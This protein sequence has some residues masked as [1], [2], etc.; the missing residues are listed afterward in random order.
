MPRPLHQKTDRRIAVMSIPHIL[1]RLPKGADLLEALHDLCA[2]HNISRGQVSLIGALEKATLGF[3]LQDKKQYISHVVDEPVEILAGIG[4][5]SL[6]DE[7]PFVHLHLTLGKQD[8]S[9]C[10]GHAMPGCP[11]FAC[12]VCILPL[13]GHPLERVLDEPTGLPLWRS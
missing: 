7:R 11:I 9:S 5:V 3:Y 8:M 4:N 10:G 6:K 13:D 2:E 1:T 12:E